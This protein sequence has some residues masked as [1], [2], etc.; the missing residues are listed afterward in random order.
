MFSTVTFET[1]TQ[2]L[3]VTYLA[4]AIVVALVSKVCL[5]IIGTIEAEN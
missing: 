2:F 1:A 5:E 4:S 3:G